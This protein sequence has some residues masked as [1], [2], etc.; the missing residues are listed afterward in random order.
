MNVNNEY[1]PYLKRFSSCYN[2]LI[3]IKNDDSISE[4][5]IG[6]KFVLLLS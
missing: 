5:T 4:T 3:E 2:I 6:N 1:Y